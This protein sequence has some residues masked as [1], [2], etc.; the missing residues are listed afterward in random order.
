MWR[1]LLAR[2]HPDAGGDHELFIWTRN[3]HDVVCSQEVQ[4]DPPPRRSSTTQKDTPRVPFD[5]AFEKAQSFAD[6][7]RQAISM[8][9]AVD[10]PYDRLLRLLEDCE[11]EDEDSPLFTQQ[12]QGA[13][14][15]TL[16]AIGH[17]AG[18]D[19]S[20]RAGWYRLAEQ[21]PLTQRHAGHILTKLKEGER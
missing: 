12:S 19:K 20:E 7:T 10:A 3:L 2:T 9:D 13:T 11:E 5:A 1:K 21:V 4:N 18:L 15:R 16:A 8:G 6:L 14:Y 17:A